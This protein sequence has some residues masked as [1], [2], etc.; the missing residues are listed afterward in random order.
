[1]WLTL[2]QLLL[3]P[4]CATHYPITNSRRTQLAKLLPLMQPVLLDQI[5]P[6]L[7]LQ[8]WLCRATMSEQPAAPHKPVLLETLL[9]IRE[10]ILKQYNNKWKKIAREQAPVIFNNDKNQLKEI[11][12][13]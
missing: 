1:M 2:R 10:S 7:E 4:A 9:T 8:Q 3:D 11:A 12:T 5:S 13:W 6:L